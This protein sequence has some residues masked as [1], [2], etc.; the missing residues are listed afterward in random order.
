MG[1]RGPVEEALMGVPVPDAGSPVNV[2]R[3]IR[4][5]DP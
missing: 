1:Q 5:F 2:G 3:V 4:A